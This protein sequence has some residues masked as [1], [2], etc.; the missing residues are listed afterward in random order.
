MN[1]KVSNVVDHTGSD[2]HKA[3]RSSKRVD[4]AKALGESAV[5]SLPIGGA[6]S[7][8]DSTT[9]TIMVM[10]DLWLQGRAERLL[11]I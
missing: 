1:Q 5:L 3:A 6:L 8:L 9:R 2:V 11:N 10:H 4:S 7:T